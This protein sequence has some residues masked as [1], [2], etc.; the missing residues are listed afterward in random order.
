M[1]IPFV[2]LDGQ[3]DRP[4]RLRK[5]ILNMS[6]SAEKAPLITTNDVMLVWGKISD[7]SYCP[8]SIVKVANSEEVNPKVFKLL[9]KS[10]NSYL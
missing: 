8:N 5:A 2:V 3:L 10:L 9:M 7:S 4:T 1:A 6:A